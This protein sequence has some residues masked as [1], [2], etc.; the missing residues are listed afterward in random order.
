[1][2]SKRDKSKCRGK[3]LARKLGVGV[4]D[5]VGAADAVAVAEENATKRRP[6]SNKARLH[7]WVVL[8]SEWCCNSRRRGRRRR[9]DGA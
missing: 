9:E 7:L 8:V 5:G 1:M 6:W 4:G 2:K 3:L